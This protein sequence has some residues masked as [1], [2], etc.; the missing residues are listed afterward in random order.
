VVGKPGLTEHI[1]IDERH[2]NPSY[3]HAIGA[4]LIRGRLFTEA[5]DASKPGVAIINASLA[6]TYFPNQD[7]IGQRFS[8]NEGGRPSVWEVVGE[9]EDVHEEPLDVPV[10]PAEYF[11]LRQTGDYGF[12]LVARTRHDPGA[13]LASIAAALHQIDR[14]IAVSDETTIDGA[15]DATQAAL[16]HR[17]S[18]WLIGSFAGA[19]LLLSVV[20]LYSVVAYSVRQR[21]REIGVRIALGA[22]R[23]AIYSLVLGQAARLIGIGMAF[24]L[25]G[26][27]GASRFLRSLLFGVHAWDPATLSAVSALLAIVSLAA[28]FLPAWRAAS[29]DPAAVLHTE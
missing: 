12:S 25:L 29:L 23:S 16:L 3:L 15:I 13:V 6:R 22:Q 24:G 11:P 26:A 27:L 19:A 7:P 20:G 2:I 4:R 9:I 14:G 10:G 17:F 8:N 1:E 18:A 21:T 5:D 28:V